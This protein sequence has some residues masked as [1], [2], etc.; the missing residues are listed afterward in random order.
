MNEGRCVRCR[1]FSELLCVLFRSSPPSFLQLLRF[2][3]VRSLEGRHS[4]GVLGSKLR[5]R[6]LRLNLG[7]FPRFRKRRLKFIV[8]LRQLSD[9]LL[10]SGGGRVGMPGLGLA[11][12]SGVL[13][14]NG[15]SAV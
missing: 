6:R 7:P 4:P 8:L 15:R 9:P 14:G 13:S 1:G 5:F 11:K 12:R 3:L 2:L 10:F